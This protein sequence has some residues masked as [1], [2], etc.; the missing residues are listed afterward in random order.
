MIA[1]NDGARGRGA[2]T[3][4]RVFVSVGLPSVAVEAIRPTLESLAEAEITGM[5]PVP[6]SAAHITVRFLGEVPVGKVGAVGEALDGAVRSFGRFSLELSG[7]GSFPPNRP[8]TVVWVGVGGDVADSHRPA[9]HSGQITRLDRAGNCQGVLHAPRHSGPVGKARLRVGKETCAQ[10]GS[11][12]SSP[13]SL[14]RC[15]RDKSRP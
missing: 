7:V 14:V 15:G 4:M 10:G 6:A 9:G 11:G 1:C 13:Q 12:V 5:R 8:P 2:C 3:R